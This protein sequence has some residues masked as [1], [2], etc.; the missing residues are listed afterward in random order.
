MKK[1]FL[2]MMACVLIAD[3]AALANPRPCYEIREIQAIPPRIGLFICDSL[4]ISGDTIYTSSG[5]A[6][7]NQGVIAPS[8]FGEFFYLDSTNTSGFVLNQESD[9]ILLDLTGYDNP[10]MWGT[11]GRNPV[12]IN[13]HTINL[14]LYSVHYIMTY[15]FSFDFSIPHQGYS[16][17][18]LNEINAHPTWNSNCG[19][20]ELYNRGN[21]YT[22][23]ENWQLVCDTILTLPQGATIAPHGFYV[24]DQ[25]QFPSGWDM[26]ST[27]DN[28][29][30]INSA[31]QTVDQVGWSSDHG[32]DVSFMRFPDGVADT[33]NYNHDYWGFDDTSSE[34]FSD[35]YPS[36]GSYNSVDSPGLRVI[37]I[38]GDT[39]NGSILIQWTNPVWLSVFTQVILRRSLETFPATPFDGDL[40]YEGV[41][42]QYLD[43]DITPG[44]RYYYTVFARTSC[45][46]YS[47]PDSQSQISMIYP[48]Q[49]IGSEPLPEKPVLLYA[50]PNPFNGLVTLTLSSV[51]NTHIAIFDI[52]GARVAELPLTGGRA[53]WDARQYSSGIYFVRALSE[54]TVTPLKLIY[55]K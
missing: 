19:F 41:D 18:V 31:N 27:G 26:D 42:Q 2:I 32:P 7:V 38:R 29:Y 6:V 49:G 16:E 30:L 21:S 4:D 15:V 36:R 40:I 50:Y 13:G 47:E 8:N 23:L 35:G 5:F 46:E 28:I 9:F 44:Q 33:S 24:I 10:I 54:K 39:V 22:N 14:K 51:T 53:V 48:G 1:T 25:S 34:S 3:V 20:I 52:T 17:I 55:L 45:G 11:S 37:G 43:R 12:P